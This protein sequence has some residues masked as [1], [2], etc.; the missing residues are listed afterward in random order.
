M[1]AKL[2]TEYKFMKCNYY[3]ENELTKFHTT[4]ANVYSI[5]ILLFFSNIKPIWY[6]CLPNG[7]IANCACTVVK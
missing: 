2:I 5:V 6:L 3:A 1:I 4:T 7:W